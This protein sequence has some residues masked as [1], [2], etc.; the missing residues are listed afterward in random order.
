MSFTLF[1]I[2][3]KNNLNWQIHIL[4]SDW[5][6]R[7]YLYDLHRNFRYT[8]SQ[9]YPSSNKFPEEHIQRVEWENKFQPD[10]GENHYKPLEL[11]L[12]SDEICHST[13]KQAD[14]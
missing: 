5:S 4:V 8:K 3:I 7:K 1:K 11:V 12:D 2:L 13:N 10:S 6:S 9:K 14:L